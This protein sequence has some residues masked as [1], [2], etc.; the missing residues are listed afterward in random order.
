MRKILNE[1]MV[2]KSIKS[3]PQKNKRTSTGIIEKKSARILHDKYVLLLGIP[4]VSL[5]MYLLFGKNMDVFF[6]SNVFIILLHNIL[7]TFLIW[8]GVRKIVIVLWEKFPWEKHPLKHLFWEI[9]LVAFYVMLISLLNYGFLIITESV[10]LIFH[11]SFL[12]SLSIALIV[13][14]FITSVHE[15]WFF[16]TQ[17]NISRLKEKTLEKE[18]L[19]SQYETL[20]SQ[21]NPHFLFNTLNT[22]TNLIEEEPEMAVRYVNKTADFLR[23][24]LNLKDKQVIR[25]EEEIDL[26]KDFYDLQLQRFADNLKL[27]INI[28]KENLSQ[29]IPPLALQM[30]FE[31]ALKHN[32]ISSENP[33]II[34]I[35]DHE[36]DYIEVKNN[37]QKKKV[38]AQ[39][40]GIGLA[41]IVSRYGFLSNK[42]VEIVENESF[43]C[44]RIP[45]LKIL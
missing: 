29:K 31:N 20:K 18:N 24:V 28:K 40:H 22:I 21:I 5:A 9:G 15:A 37:L 43:F 35:K 41:N 19:Q 39:S 6:S 30:L 44:V 13:T 16:Y 27:H 2:L 14:Y 3:F 10:D 12:M 42:K 33:L 7:M 32:V 26:I 25:V 38:F 45:L 11:G 1:K 34:T 23:T 36:Q 4:T 17:W 8:M